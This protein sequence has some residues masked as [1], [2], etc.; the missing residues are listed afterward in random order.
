[1]AGRSPRRWLRSFRRGRDI[2]DRRSVFSISGWVVTLC[3]GLMGAGCTSLPARVQ[4]RLDRGAYEEARVLLDQAGVGEALD[5]RASEKALSAREAFT[6]HIESMTIANADE[7]GE[8]Q[9]DAYCE[10]VRQG[11]ALAPWSEPLHARMR[12]CEE[13]LQVLEDLSVRWPNSPT[14]VDDARRALAD[15][16]SVG[17]DLRQRP[18]LTEVLEAS[19][20]LVFDH[21]MR[22][23]EEPQ[24]F[25][26]KDE[27]S[28]FWGDIQALGPAALRY[29][30]CVGAAVAL[31][32]AD[33]ESNRSL[34][35]RNLRAALEQSARCVSLG[36]PSYGWQRAEAIA[37]ASRAWIVRWLSDNLVDM[38]SRE[39][40]SWGVVAAYEDFLSDHVEVTDPGLRCAVANLHLRLGEDR[41]GRGAAA[42]LALLHGTRAEE[43]C[44]GLP[45]ARIGALRR[46]AVASLRASDGLGAEL[47]IVAAPD[48]DPQAYEIVRVALA[49]SLRERSRTGF[50]WRLLPPGQRSGS[51]NI[52]LHEVDLVVPD[53]EALPRVTSSYHSHNEEV[54]NPQRQL[55][56][57]RLQMQERSVESAKSSLES[58][59]RIYSMSPSPYLLPTLNAAKN[60]YSYQV[61][62][63]N[64]LVNQYN[65]TPP[66]VVRPVYL[67]YS[68]VEGNIE[69]GWKLGLSY[70]IGS[71]SGRSYHESFD[72]DYVRIGTRYNDRS[73]D[74]RQDREPSFEISV[75]RTIG[76]LVK[77]V[78][79]AVDEMFGAFVELVELRFAAGLTEDE[80][81]VVRWIFHP[82]GGTKELARSMMIPAWAIEVAD[83]VELPEFE[84]VPPAVWVGA[85]SR[86]PPLPLDAAGAAQWFEGLVGEV[87]AEGPSGRSISSGAIISGDG[88]VLTCAH[89]LEGA[90]L[91]F[92]LT[93][94]NWVGTYAA[95]IEFVHELSDTA[96]LR[97]R[98]LRTTRWMEVRL[99]RPAQRGE[100]IVAIGNP[101]LPGGSHSV[102]AISR[103]IVS[104]PESEFY[105]L[106][107]LVADVAIASGSS[108]GP[109]VS[110]Q[111]GKIVG[112]TV[113]VARP[114]F[115]SG[116][117]STK[118]VCLAAPAHRLSEWL[119]LARES[120]A[121]ASR[122]R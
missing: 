88:L 74:R 59:L 46:R 101:S 7:H 49:A 51:A 9:V 56:L 61:D 54:P 98:G 66:T 106:P 57:S 64:A 121:G 112:V 115:G 32:L 116:R 53:V 29:D 48:V 26:A 52:V 30:R 96:I 25:V 43:L 68:F 122:W 113:A 76:H 31:S 63:Y 97:V 92:R 77:V 79:E 42:V 93:S 103:G 85:P 70:Q 41:A 65:A 5:E 73:P 109:L 50:Q 83:R 19:E 11:F 67:P 22:R 24:S 27:V 36:P 16:R 72:R 37:G 13:R 118:S 23:L 60:N 78:N 90:R 87:V 114:E 86:R 94:G 82:L 10:I 117:A 71:A 104:N 81:Q 91:S 18:R 100:E 33:H 45:P 75:E 2:V 69:Q 15:L 80:R 107:R 108:G 8:G 17:P 102:E 89:C 3:W 4:D 14:A 99:D 105:G 34:T 120:P 1:M 55:L 110:L 84:P 58:A 95:E 28:E 44:G 21:W 39:E 6:N 35:D 111:D 119:G 12:S 38:A 47:A 20:G 62:V 40:A